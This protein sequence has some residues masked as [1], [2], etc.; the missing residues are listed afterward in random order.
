MNFNLRG[1]HFDWLYKCLPNE[2][3]TLFEDRSAQRGV[4]Y[5]EHHYGEEKKEKETA[6]M[7]ERS[8][9]QAVRY[10]PENGTPRVSWASL[11]LKQEQQ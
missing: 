7:S 1:S 3:G 4:A 2:E 6:M 11:L 5:G 10:S 8:W 9:R